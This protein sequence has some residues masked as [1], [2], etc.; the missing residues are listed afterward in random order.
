MTTQIVRYAGFANESA[1]DAL[2]SAQVHV[3]IASSSLDVPGDTQIEWQGGM[4]RAR[5]THRPGYYAPEGDVEMAFDVETVGRFLRYVLGG[6]VFTSNTTAPN[7]HEI[8]GVP[9]RDLPMFSTRIGKD[10]FEH[11]FEGCLA[12]SLTLNVEDE[13]AML[14]M[15]ILAR[16]DSDQPIQAVEDLMLPAAYPL[17]FHEVTFSAGGSDVSAKVRSLDLS[18]ENGGDAGEGRGLGSRHPYRQRA[19][20]RNVELSL[21]LYYEDQTELER[22]WGATGGPSETGSSEYEGII[23]FDAGAD[24]SM[25]LTLPRLVNWTVEQQPS[26]RDAMEQ[27]VTAQAFAGDTTLIDGTTNVDTE[28]YC[29][30]QNSISDYAAS[31]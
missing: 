8:Y 13:F 7:D 10:I 19:N 4:G 16:A 26:G 15:G 27:S 6:Y 22:L 3:D 31:A 30:L 23:T 12:N 24:G 14:T 9:D 5:Q 18:I 29:H 25:D 1:I 11:A 17:A 21:T 20:A 2:S 28:V